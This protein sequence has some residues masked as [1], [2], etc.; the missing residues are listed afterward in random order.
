MGND[1]QDERPTFMDKENN[2]EDNN[3]LEEQFHN[4]QGKFPFIRE[5]CCSRENQASRLHQTLQ[6]MLEL[7][8]QEL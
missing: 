4:R 2:D 7:R 1:A 5:S 3:T 6:T 8:Y